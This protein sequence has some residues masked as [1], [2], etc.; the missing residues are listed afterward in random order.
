[1]ETQEVC[2][3]VSNISLATYDMEPLLFG[4]LSIC[5]SPNGEAAN[6][7]FHFSTKVCVYWTLCW[8]LTPISCSR[9]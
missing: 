9:F 8:M 2:A 6:V 3:F 4:T 1:M 7:G 5:F